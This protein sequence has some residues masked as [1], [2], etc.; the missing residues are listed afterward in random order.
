MYCNRHF[1]ARDT[2]CKEE[3]YEVEVQSMQ[4]SVAH[5]ASGSARQPVERAHRLEEHLDADESY[6][7]DMD[8][9]LAETR[10][11][12]MRRK[13]EHRSPP[14]SQVSEDVGL[15]LLAKKS[16]FRSSYDWSKVEPQ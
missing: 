1:S 10:R 14:N 6:P 7:Y 9:D 4:Q 12:P 13:H 11:L 16:V 15:V 2:G 5:M 3:I 8:R